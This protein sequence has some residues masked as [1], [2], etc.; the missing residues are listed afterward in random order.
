MNKKNTIRTHRNIEVAVGAIEAALGG[1][2]PGGGVFGGAPLR[3]RG[4]LAGTLHVEADA[5]FRA[6]C[7]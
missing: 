1:T 2:L 6:R 7:P 3:G 4:G 5:L